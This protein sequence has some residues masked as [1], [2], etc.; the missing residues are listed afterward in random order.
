MN[1]L[2]NVLKKQARRPRSRQGM[3]LGLVMVFVLAVSILGIS[4]ISAATM[5]ALETSRYLNSVKAFWLAD[6]GVQRY[7]GRA[8]S[9]T[10]NFSGFTYLLGDGQVQVTIISSTSNLV[11]SVGTVLGVEQKIRFRFAVLPT[12]YEKVIYGANVSGNPWTFA[13]RGTGVPDAS[14][15][16]GRDILMGDV[17]ANGD[18]KFYEQSI[19]S[20]APAPN[21]Y[22]LL[23][24][25][26]AT[27]T[28]SNAPT[29]T[30]RGG[31][32]PNSPTN[33]LPNLL[34]A[35]YAANNTWNVA[36]EFLDH[37]ADSAG[38]LPVGHPLRNVVK[39]NPSD[40]AARNS[41]TTG[42]DYYFEPLTFVLGTAKTA[43]TPLG[44]G[45]RQ[46]YYVDG[47][48]WFNSA[49]TYG[50]L[51]SG[52]ATIAATA[53]IHISDN[54]KYATG[55]NGSDL[56][57]LVA[58]GTYNSSGKLISGGNVY[59]GDPEYGTL[60]TAD[61]YM[62]AASNFNYNISASTPTLQAEPSTGFQVFGNYAAMNQVNVYRDW[63]TTNGLARAA[64]FKSG[65]NRWV[66]AL[67]SAVLATN[68][69]FRHY[70]MIVKYDERIRNQATQPPGLPGLQ[71]GT[72]G[73]Y[74]EIFDWKLYPY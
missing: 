38:R 19:V 24:D 67:T 6:A 62:L 9:V 47:H 10:P 51:I 72:N 49:S 5:N 7:K 31:S 60:Y 48:V 57:G 22:G 61:A 15:V 44:L 3:A 25:V 11:E 74:K 69:V 35:N 23:G 39:K 53:D 73:I 34:D 26:R 13:L 1:K 40:R 16:G 52:T 42:D 54:L 2:V 12:I 20:N 27:G 17:F 14:D 58:A 37:G 46:V 18:V 21:T 68:T 64:W 32:Y 50:F 41:S 33:A 65:T 4:L 56:L 71:S 30:I 63:Y 66:D 45:V 59:F 70:Q 55:N 36:Q 28:I 8:A 43:A 29:A